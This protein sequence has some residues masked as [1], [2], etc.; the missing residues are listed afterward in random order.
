MILCISAMGTF[1]GSFTLCV[2]AQEPPA[3]QPPS[4]RDSTKSTVAVQL[5]EQPVQTPDESYKAAMHP[6]DIVRGSLDNWSEAELG[7][8]AVGM[9]KAHD[10]CETAQLDDYSGDNLYDFVRLCALGQDWEKANAAAQSYIRSKL[11]PHRA[12]AYSLSI[13]AMVHMS[14]ID[15][16]VETTREMLTQL[17]YDAEV[18]YAV[19][20]MKDDLS[21]TSDPAALK[22]AGEEHPAIVAALK[23]NAP[24]KAQGEAVMSLGSLYDSA[25]E[26][27]FWQRYTRDDAAASTT[28]EEV[29]QALGPNAPL[30]AEDTA[31]IAAVRLRYGL[32]G[33]RLPEIKPMRSLESA[34]AKPMIPIGGGAWT[35]LVLFPDWCGGCRKMMKPLTEFAKVNKIRAFGLVF[36]DDSVIPEQAGHELLLNELKGTSTMVVSPSTAQLVGANEFPLG[37]VLDRERKV[38]FIGILPLNAFNGGGYMERTIQQIAGQGSS[39][40]MPANPAKKY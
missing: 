16:A 2:P 27:A 31:R 19:R 1:I 22:L 29:D 15:L 7:A 4:D 24:L 32:L 13:N 9:R 30:S 33:S 34:K 20:Y 40:A 17:A 3:G 10:A 38:R 14:A 39:V 12:Q 18:A 8:L 5:A 28:T 21:Q 23:G 36:E 6:L 25:M 37:I 35:V 26:L 11:E